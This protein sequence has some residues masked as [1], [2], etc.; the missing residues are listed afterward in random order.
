[1]LNCVLKVWGKLT[2]SAHITVAG[3]GQWPLVGTLNLIAKVSLSVEGHFAIWGFE[4]HAVGSRHI[5]TQNQMRARL[6]PSRDPVNLQLFNYL[7]HNIILYSISSKLM[8][9]TWI[10]YACPYYSMIVVPH[11]P[12]T[13]NNSALSTLYMCCL[14]NDTMHSKRPPDMSGIP[15][16]MHEAVL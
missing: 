7:K 10:Q 15:R 12:W 8:H 4:M 13:G 3:G 5:V 11:V 14:L 6:P 1:M 9:F 2:L 16:T